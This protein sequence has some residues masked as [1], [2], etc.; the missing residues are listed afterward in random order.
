MSKVYAIYSGN[1]KSAFSQVIRHRITPKN[2]PLFPYSH[3]GLIIEPKAE[4]I[5]VDSLVTHSSFKG[6]GVH[7]TTVKNFIAH[8][9]QYQIN[10]FDEETENFSMLM[11]LAKIY[12]GTPYDLQGAIGLGVGEDWQIDSDFWCS[13]WD[14][15][16]L[17]HMGF[18]FM[19]H[20]IEHRIDPRHHFL[21]PQ[22]KVDLKLLSTR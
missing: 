14:A 12:D 13:E 5:T 15:F 6:K 17:K 21:W 8:A 9:T 3:C 4:L 18:S 2:E 16:I 1:N 20:D 19:Q 10:V 7:F 22:T 11:E